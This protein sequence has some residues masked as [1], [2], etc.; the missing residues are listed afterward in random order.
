MGSDRLPAPQGQALASVIQGI[1]GGDVPMDKYLAGAGLGAL[2]SASG[3]GGIGVMNIMLVAV[4]ERTREIG[5]RRAV[6]ALRRD[7]LW[8]FLTESMLL[9]L[10]GGVVGAG[11]GVVD[12]IVSPTFTLI[13]EY[14]GRLVLYHVDLYRIGDPDEAPAERIQANHPGVHLRDADGQRIERILAALAN[15]IDGRLLVGDLLAEFEDLV[16]Q[17]GRFLELQRLRRFQA[18]FH[19]P[20]SAGH[21]QS[22]D[23]LPG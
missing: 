11:L 9:A 17:H 10:L 8:Q 15:F 2:L 21:L 1:L 6:G 3:V 22:S 19:G 13:N 4:A 12:R 7:I 20:D 14:P 23:F 16:A 18:R 5:L